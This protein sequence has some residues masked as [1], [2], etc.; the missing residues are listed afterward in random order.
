[1]KF[2]AAI[3]LLSLGAVNALDLTADNYEASTAGML[4]KD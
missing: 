3:A 1:M 2:V 4:L